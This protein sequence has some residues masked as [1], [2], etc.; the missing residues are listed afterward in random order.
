[1]QRA[2]PVQA[3]PVVASV[4]RLALYNYLGLGLLLTHRHL[5]Y[6]PHYESSWAKAT[7][8]EVFDSNPRHV[9]KERA[10]QYGERRLVQRC[11]TTYSLA[12]DMGL[13]RQE[14][15]LLQVTRPGLVRPLLIAHRA[16]LTSYSP[17]APSS[18]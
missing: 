3:I 5:T 1:M 8:S 15:E 14:P 6:A 12:T 13:G 9:E 4:R 16:A 18:R 2:W 7:F 17:T 11:S 10:A